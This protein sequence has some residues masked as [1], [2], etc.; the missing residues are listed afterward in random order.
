[1]IKTDK[2]MDGKIIKFYEEDHIY[3]TDNVKDFTSAT[4]FIKQ[5]F[6]KFDRDGIATKVAKARRVSVESILKEWEDAGKFG[7]AV[8]YYCECA[9]LGQPLPQ[10]TSEREELYFKQCDNYITK[11]LDVVS[12]IEA[13]KIVFSEKYKIAGMIDLVV[14]DC[15]KNITYI[16][17]WKTNKK[18]YLKPFG[19]KLGTGPCSNIPDCNYY[20]Y[21]L[22]L[23]LYKKLLIEEYGFT[24]DIDM[25]LA[26]ISQDG[27]TS[28]K[29]DDRQDVIQNMFQYKL[30][31]L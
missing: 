3:E 27:V 18:I 7:T 23:N 11:M 29:L 26:H 21:E 24:G 31:N 13:E 17:D 19:A 4:T 9:V 20:H 25:V 5:F 8:H 16:V 1:M 15:D 14:E 10:P 30:E 22:Q 12:V 6:S 2:N 28:Y